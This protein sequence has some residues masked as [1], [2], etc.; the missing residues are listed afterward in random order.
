[1]PIKFSNWNQPTPITPKMV[2][3]TLAAI[4][5]LI[6]VYFASNPVI[7]TIAFVCAGISLLLQQFYGYEQP[8]NIRM[9]DHISPPGDGDTPKSG[10]VQ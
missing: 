5:A 10:E 1:M 2:G 6:G 8:T 4:S 3:V 9:D 7:M